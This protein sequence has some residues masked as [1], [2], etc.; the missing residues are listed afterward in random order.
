MIVSGL[1]KARRE[2]L[3][4]ML[5]VVRKNLIDDSNHSK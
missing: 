3:V 2:S 5:L 1:S 4:D